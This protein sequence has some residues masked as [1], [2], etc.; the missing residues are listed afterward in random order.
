MRSGAAWIPL[1]ALCAGA[2]GPVSAASTPSQPAPAV[3]GPDAFGSVAL[4]LGPNRYTQRWRRAAAGGG[5]PRLIELISPARQMNRSGQ[6]RFVN[7]A[8]NRRI[9]FRPDAGDR[10]STASETM[11]RAAGDCED[12]AI[13]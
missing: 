3:A 10:W 8:L 7:A 11:S 5:P 9:A 4:P 13:A 6:A 1:L 12:Y 2:V